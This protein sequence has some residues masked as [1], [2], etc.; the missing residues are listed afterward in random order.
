MHLEFSPQPDIL[1]VDRQRRILAGFKLTAWTMLLHDYWSHYIRIIPD[2]P[3]KSREYL[4]SR[5]GDFLLS[6]IQFS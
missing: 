2:G 6:Q 5:D 1:C 3:I 4:P